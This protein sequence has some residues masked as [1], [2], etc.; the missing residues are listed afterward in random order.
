MKLWILEPAEPWAPWY[1]KV[2]GSIVR[3]D[4]ENRARDIAAEN[5]GDEGP[6]VW[7]DPEKTTCRELAADGEAGLILQ[8]CAEA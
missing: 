2:F 8:D 1:D 7:R 4:T 5:H 6:L 3:A